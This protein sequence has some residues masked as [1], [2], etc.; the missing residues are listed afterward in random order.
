MK[1]VSKYA[2]DY[3]DTTT[4]LLAKYGSLSLIG[5]RTEQK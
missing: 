5:V 2:T 1:E 4:Q 3:Y